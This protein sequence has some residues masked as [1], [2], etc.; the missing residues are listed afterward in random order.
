MARPLP[1]K[2]MHFTHMENLPSIVADG[3]VGDTAAQAPGV[4]K[5]EV[6]EPSIKEARRR[7]QVDIPPGGVV[8]DYVPFYFAPYSPMMDAI[9]HGKVA[10]YQDGCAPLVYLVTTV[11]RLLELGLDV[12][13]SDRNARLELAEFHGAVGDAW[14]DVIDWSL[15]RSKYW[16]STL[17][18]PDRKE[19]RMA[20][21]LS[22]QTVPWDAFLEVVV[23]NAGWKSKAE[24]AIADVGHG[25]PVSVR[26]G[27]YTYGVW[28]LR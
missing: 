19:R 17:E 3:L 23:S 8:A 2:V 9:S 12:V 27:W 11:E 21:C 7:R 1:T 28:D 5:V 20:E 6:G 18:E 16:G 4:L 10:Q 25:T 14:D 22:R 24:R 13:V 26:P 15:M